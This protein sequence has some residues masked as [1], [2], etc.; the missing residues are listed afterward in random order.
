MTSS[1]FESVMII[2]SSAVIWKKASDDRYL[3]KRDVAQ[4]KSAPS[5]K[6]G[7]AGLNSGQNPPGS[8]QINAS[9]SHRL[10]PPLVSLGL[11]PP[12]LWV[13]AVQHQNKLDL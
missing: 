10:F 6:L 5:L 7:Y 4:L 11:P 13:G 2:F 12:R 1:T 9:D 8:A 3:S